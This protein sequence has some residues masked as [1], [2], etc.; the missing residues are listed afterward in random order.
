MV[1]ELFIISQTV[2]GM[3]WGVPQG[4]IPDPLLFLVYVNDLFKVF[5]LLPRI[6]LADDANVLL[7]NRNKI[8]LFFQPI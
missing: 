6:I 3:K 2:C 7:A 5:P 4:S 8:E 1:S